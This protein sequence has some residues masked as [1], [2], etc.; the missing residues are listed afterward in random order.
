MARIDGFN[1]PLNL[2]GFLLIRKH[3]IPPE[4]THKT[5]LWEKKKGLTTKQSKNTN[6]Q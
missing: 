5:S 1:I 6:T 4:N 3:L 2:E